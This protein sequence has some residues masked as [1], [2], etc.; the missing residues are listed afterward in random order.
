MIC[1]KNTNQLNDDVLKL[2]TD[3]HLCWRWFDNSDSGWINHV[4]YTVDSFLNRC[5]FVFSSWGFLTLG[6]EE[7]TERGQT[8]QG[9]NKLQLWYYFFRVIVA[10]AFHTLSQH[11]LEGFVCS[12]E[13]LQTFS[14]HWQSLGSSLWHVCRALFSETHSP[15]LLNCISKLHDIILTLGREPNDFGNPVCILM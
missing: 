5:G 15:L 4:V 12:T 2:N 1:T 7:E 11:V 14:P 13:L 6:S 9:E 10:V 3:R 8:A